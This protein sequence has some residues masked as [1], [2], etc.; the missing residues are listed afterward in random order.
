M[1]PIK[2]SAELHRSVFEDRPADEIV[3]AW[4]DPHRRVVAKAIALME[5][6]SGKSR[7][8]TR[9]LD[10]PGQSN[11]DQTVAYR[12]EKAGRERPGTVYDPNEGDL[13]LEIM[14]RRAGEDRDEGESERV[15]H[16]EMDPGMAGYNLMGYAGRSGPFAVRRGG[17]EDRSVG[18]TMPGELED[19]LDPERDERFTDIEDTLNLMARLAIAEG[20]TTAEALIFSLAFVAED[21]AEPSPAPAAAA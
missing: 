20:R 10:D 3:A 11:G 8:A 16:F 17:F 13:F 18:V 15:A 12:I 7:N 2:P 6:V 14:L 5:Q 1:P 21:L 4:I 9:W 19:V